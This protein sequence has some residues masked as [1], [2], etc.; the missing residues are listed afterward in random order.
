MRGQ[1]K[2]FALVVDEIF[3]HQQVVIKQLGEEAHY[4]KGYMGSSILGDGLPA[5][6]L[7]LFELVEDR[8]SKR[9][10]MNN[11]ELEKGAA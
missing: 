3:H 6:I 10:I 8:F 5:V 7:D 9:K 11:K 4:R 2:S 1:D